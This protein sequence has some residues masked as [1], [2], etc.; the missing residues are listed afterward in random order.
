MATRTPLP[1][2]WDIDQTLVNISDVSREFYRPR[3]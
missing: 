3:L 2:L 1:V